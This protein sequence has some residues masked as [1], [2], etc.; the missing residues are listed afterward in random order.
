M[1]QASGPVA[2]FDTCLTECDSVEILA[3]HVRRSCGVPV[4]AL[5]VTALLETAGLNDSIARRRYDYNDLFEL[6]ASV[7]ERIASS[8]PAT[9]D[10]AGAHTPITKPASWQVIL[11]D[12]L[13]GPL[14]LLP[15]VLLAIVTNFIQAFGRWEKTQVLILSA[16]TVGSLLVTSGFVQVAARKGSSY[17]SQ[18][19]VR[20][21][22]RFLRLA[23]RW[24][25][26][27]VL[28][29]AALATGLAALF[30]WLTPSDLVLMLVAYLSLSGLWILAA[31]YAVLD[32][33]AWFALALGVSIAL[34]Y[35]AVV[36]LRATPLER[37]A[38][39]ALAYVIALGALAAIS[40]VVIRRSFAQRRAEVADESQTVILPPLP[41][42]VVGLAP[43]FVYG[44]VYALAL[45]SGHVGAWVGRLPAGASRDAAVT[46]GEIGLTVALSVL[47]VTSGVPHRTIRRFWDQVARYQRAIS[48]ADLGAFR[49][50]VQRYIRRQRQLF[51]VVL[52]VTGAIVY[53]I[54]AFLT[55]GGAIP[56]LPQGASVMPTV[57]VTGLGLIGY[58][59]LA[60]AVFDCMFLITLSRPLPAVSAVAT[61]ALVTLVSGIA[62]ALLF[63]YPFG[64]LGTVIGGAVTLRLARRQLQELLDAAAYHYYASF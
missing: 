25:L 42:L 19:Q 58:G 52:T 21:A 51:V 15:L 43:Y 31:I 40:S 35:G 3:E 41:Q 12:Y 6:G 4:N 48:A 38:I 33:T 29:T 13:Q 63:T 44:L 26:V 49:A 57:V 14:G 50:S 62:A 46:A 64:A 45:L 47:I 56:S 27:T 8:P 30:R 1:S 23:V 36:L 37:P 60:A 22:G 2:D 10:D 28:A 9:P 24:A 53:A 39:A 18:H 5:Q 59:L 20:A 61:G 54:V 7:T 11:G 32:Q 17:L 16:S 34:G 55:S